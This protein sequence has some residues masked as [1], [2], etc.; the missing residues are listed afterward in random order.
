MFHVENLNGANYEEELKFCTALITALEYIVQVCEEHP[1]R[2]PALMADVVCLIQGR[3]ASCN[4]EKV[5][6]NGLEEQ[7]QELYDSLGRLELEVQYEG[8]DYE[9][10]G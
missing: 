3:V 7:I 2:Y 8:D 10:E 6:V 1:V 9:R 4:G 5:F